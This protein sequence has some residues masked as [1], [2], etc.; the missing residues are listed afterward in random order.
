MIFMLKKSLKLYLHSDI[1]SMQHRVT[2]GVL[3]SK[4]RCHIMIE[5]DT[6]KTLSQLSDIFEVF[7]KDIV[8]LIAQIEEYIKSIKTALGI[9]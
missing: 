1:I 7:A 9:E 5:K 6:T 2:Y 3:Y 8:D 4:A